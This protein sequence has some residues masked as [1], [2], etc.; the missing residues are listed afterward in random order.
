VCANIVE[1]SI[2]IH[3]K[4][5]WN[6]FPLV[7]LKRRNIQSRYYCIILSGVSDLLGVISTMIAPTAEDFKKEIRQLLFEAQGASRSYVDVNSGELHRKVGGYPGR[8][9]RMRDCCSVMRQF[10]KPGDEV[11]S[12]PPSGQGASLTIRYYLSR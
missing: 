12:E 4:R 9:H 6:L 2:N 8:N 11:L 10:M 5:D 7:K 1:L 3:L